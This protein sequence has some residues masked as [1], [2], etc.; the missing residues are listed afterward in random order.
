MIEKSQI[1]SNFST[2]VLLHSPLSAVGR[3]NTVY[4]R[5][6]KLQKCALPLI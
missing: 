3:K 1:C 2:Y 5:K 6:Y 4:L